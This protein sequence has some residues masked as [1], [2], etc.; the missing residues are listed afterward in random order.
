VGPPY[1]F[2]PAVSGDG[3]HHIH[4]DTAVTVF[5]LP[6]FTGDIEIAEYV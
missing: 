2:D 6:G 5:N 1:L 4:A 3:R